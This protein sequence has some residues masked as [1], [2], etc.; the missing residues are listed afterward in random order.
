M[1][2]EQA[3]S[4]VLVQQA[5][6]EEGVLQGQVKQQVRN[7]GDTGFPIDCGAGPAD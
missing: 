6:G 5:L 4:T 1:L 2:L 7:V 3:T